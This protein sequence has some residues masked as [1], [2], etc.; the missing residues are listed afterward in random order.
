MPPQLLPENATWSNY[1]EVWSVVPIPTYIMNSLILTFFG[2][3]LPLIT[4]SA[5][6]FPLARMRFK[7]RHF[8]FILIL[9]TMMIPNEVT[10][11]PVYLVINALGMMDSFT[12]VILPGALTPFGIFL[13]RQAFVNIPREIEESAIID[14]A[15]VWQIFWRILLPMVKPMLGTLAILSFIGAWNSFLWPLLILQDQSMYPLTVGLYKLQGTFVTNTRLVAAGA[16]IA[17]IP[18]IIVFVALQRSFIDA[19]ISSSVKG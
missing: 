10:M 5:A 17:L 14:G 13:M 8:L 6:A 9:A 3:L 7:G 12:G 19:A 4:S 15:N 2:V 16:M 1:L 11:I 18:V